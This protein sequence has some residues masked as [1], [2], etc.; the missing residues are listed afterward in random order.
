[1]DIISN[2]QTAIVVNGTL[3][4]APSQV[5]V[6]IRKH[7]TLST[8]FPQG[9]G[10][11]P[12][13]GKGLAR[14]AD[15][16]T[17]YFS[18]GSLEQYIFNPDNTWSTTGGTPSNDVVIYPCQGFQVT[19]GAPTELTVGGGDVSYVKSTPTQIPLY[20]TGVNLVGL[21]NPVVAPSPGVSTTADE[22][23][24]LQQ[25]GFHSIP[26]VL[27]EA[28]TF[29]LFSI[30][31]SFAQTPYFVAPSLTGMIDAGSVSA[32]S[33]TIQNGAAAYIVP[34]AD[35]TWTAPVLHPH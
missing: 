5:T 19:C 35:L 29:T 13:N 15:Y 30:D 20:V 1:L 28:D 12:N 4:A 27:A 32:N 34:N 25:Y 14:E 8:I 10:T 22:R 6:A 17:L 2:T 21:L 11:D 24:T 31:G 18:D 26:D 23:A 9:G 3:P 16:I 7:A 33:V